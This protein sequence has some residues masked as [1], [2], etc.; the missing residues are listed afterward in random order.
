[1]NKRTL[2]WLKVAVWI[3]CLAPLGRLAFLGI[4]P[5]LGSNPIEFIT[6]ATGTWALVFLLVTLSVTPLRKLTGVNWLTRFRRLLGLFAFFYG[7]LHFG[8][9]IWLDKF[10]DFSEMAKDVVKRP[11]IT[12]G[13]CG[14]VLMI[15][16]ALTST[17]GAIRRL[18]RK[19]QLLHRLAY[20]AAIAAVIH[21]WWKVKADIRLPAI[22]AS[23]LTVLLLSRLFFRFRRRSAV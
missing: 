20:F 11:F 5:G 21:F 19:W 12:A 4:G 13:F 10:F 18:G 15:P 7:C 1:V 9:Y 14:F 8:I 23:V 6:L 2:T 22:Y 16:L 3:A 17:T